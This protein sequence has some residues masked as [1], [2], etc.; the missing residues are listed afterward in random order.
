M[1]VTRIATAQTSALLAGNLTSHT[2]DR[3]V[4]VNPSAGPYV[5]GIVL[6]GFT[7]DVSLT[8]DTVTCTW[9][10][11]TPVD[12]LASPLLFGSSM[13]MLMGWIVENPVSGTV[14]VSH[15][16][17]GTSTWAKARF[18][19][20][21][22]WSQAQQ[23]DLVNIQAAVVSAVGSSNVTSHTV[24]VPSILPASRVIAGHLVG[25][26]KKITA[27]NG[28]KVA[29]AN[30]AGTPNS[31]SGNGQMILGELRG[32][33][34]VDSTVTHSISTDLWAALGLNI[35]PAALTFGAK[36]THKAGKGSFGASVYRFAEPH[37]D[38]LYMVPPVGAANDQVLAGNF[39]RSLDGVPMPVYVKDPDDTS[40]Y[41]LDW[42]NHLADDDKI[43][44]VECTTSGSL[45]MISQPALDDA[46][47]LTQ[48]WITGSTVNVTRSVR[49]RCST[50][51]GRRFDRTFW[52]AGSQG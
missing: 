15:T 49:V 48:V 38:R 11:G 17:I 32:A 36:G 7:S 44:H 39:I 8:G 16:G 34:S 37:P 28:T 30:S 40:D 25:R 24:T 41:T 46:G 5:Y 35:N 52:I 18:L 21:G 14:Q 26:G 31:P 6:Y 43:I 9:T 33:P 29:A 20:V 1:P 3:A 4:N 27:Y 13:N 51:K 22:V 2:I 47:V 45:R 19:E 23:L 10:G 12:L 42:S 50:A